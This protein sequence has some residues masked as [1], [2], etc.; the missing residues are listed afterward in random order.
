MK[1]YLLKCFQVDYNQA[2]ENP[3]LADEGI[4]QALSYRRKY[5]SLEFQ[6]CFVSSSIADYSSAMI[7]L[8]NKIAIIRDDRLNDEKNIIKLTEF[9]EYLNSNFSLNTIL[10]VASSAVIDWLHKKIENSI[11]LI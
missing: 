6:N 11:I 1:V 8:D 7:F 2:K 4:Q 3:P 10:I 5:K 9:L